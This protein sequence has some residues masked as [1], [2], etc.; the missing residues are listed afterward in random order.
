MIPKFTIDI[1][2]GVSSGFDGVRYAKL[3]KGSKDGRYELLFRPQPRWDVSSMNDYYH[4]PVRKFFKMMLAKDGNPLTVAEVKELH[5]HRHGIKGK[6]GIPVSVK[7][8]DFEVWKQFL[9]DIGNDSMAWFQQ[10]LP[11]AEEIG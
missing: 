6:H 4:G 8:Y 3:I 5:K 1:E 7:T 11:I 2:D 9:T 10:E